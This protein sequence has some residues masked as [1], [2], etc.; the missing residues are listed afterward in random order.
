ME[1]ALKDTWRTNR[2]Y[3]KILSGDYNKDMPLKRIPGRMTNLKNVDN[4]EKYVEAFMIPCQHN[5]AEKKNKYFADK[6]FKCGIPL[7]ATSSK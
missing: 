5:L 6:F 3:N 1:E 4:V 2:K 7:V